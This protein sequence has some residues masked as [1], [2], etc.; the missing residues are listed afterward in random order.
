MALTMQSF[1]N[2]ANKVATGTLF[3]AAPTNDEERRATIEKMFASY[4]AKSFPNVHDA[5]PKEIQKDLEAKADAD[6]AEAKNKPVL[7]D[8]RP[9]GEQVS[10]VPGSIRE[11]DLKVQDVPKDTEIVLYCTVGYRS[12]V[13][14]A[15]LQKEYPDHKFANLKGGILLVS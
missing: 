12:G 15:Q 10:S 9:K 1:M 14:A 13:K 5:E 4:K 3:D 2:F 11:E 6:D 8:C 7:V